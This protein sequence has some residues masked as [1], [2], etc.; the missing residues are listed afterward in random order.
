M[1]VKTLC[2]SGC[3][4]RLSSSKTN[5]ARA[6]RLVADR[7]LPFPV[8]RPRRL[9]LLLLLVLCYRPHYRSDCS[10]VRP[11]RLSRVCVCVCVGGCPRRHV[12]LTATFAVAREGPTMEQAL[13]LPRLHL[14][15][16]ATHHPKF[17]DPID[18][19]T[20]PFPPPTWSVQL[21]TCVYRPTT[22]SRARAR[23]ILH[24]TFLLTIVFM[25][26]YCCVCL[27]S[28]VSSIRCLH[29][30]PRS[31]ALLDV[32]KDHLLIATV[33]CFIRDAIA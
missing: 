8:R 23:S 16:F 24:R 12:L 29:E 28:P 11:L 10:V 20:V 33:S 4:V 30:P 21:D 22:C 32:Y 9:L 14:D 26:L 3:H 17:L 18:P 15:T 6:G 2:S 7:R 27:R 5:D 19:P 1:S 13:Q 25:V 31:I